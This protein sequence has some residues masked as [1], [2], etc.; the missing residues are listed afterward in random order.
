[1]EGKN[2]PERLLRKILELDAIQ[3]LGVC[4]IIGVEVYEEEDIDARPVVED[5]HEGEQIRLEDGSP[6]DF[7][8]IWSDVCDTIAA[9]NRVKRRNLGKLLYAATKKEK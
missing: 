1:M 3:F 7:V 9:M 4:K 5:G 6:R 8:D 2:S